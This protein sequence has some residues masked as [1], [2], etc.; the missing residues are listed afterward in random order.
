MVSPFAWRCLAGSSLETAECRG[1]ANCPH[2]LMLPQIVQHP[3]PQHQWICLCSF[4]FLC[5][6]TLSFPRTCCWWVNGVIVTVATCWYLRT[7]STKTLSFQDGISLALSCMSDEWARSL[8]IVL[9]RV[10]YP[11]FP[12]ALLPPLLWAPCL[13]SSPDPHTTEICCWAPLLLWLPRP[14]PRWH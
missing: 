10:G 4:I 8:G 6:C 12:W 7:S 2:G 14:W 1:M 9:F 5:L 13:F 11:Y 3:C